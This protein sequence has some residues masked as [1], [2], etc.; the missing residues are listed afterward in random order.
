M[1]LGVVVSGGGGR[2]YVSTELFLPST[3]KTCLLQDGTSR[4]AHTLDQLED[5]TLLA[6]GGH[7]ICKKDR[8]AS[9][10]C[11]KCVPSPPYGQWVMST[12]LWTGRAGHTSAVLGGKVVLFGGTPNSDTA[13]VVGG[14]QSETFKLQTHIQ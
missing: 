11:D 1:V 5:G 10:S 7:C 14:Y 13:E 6:C 2:H 9:R 8:P 12:G 4:F 3:G